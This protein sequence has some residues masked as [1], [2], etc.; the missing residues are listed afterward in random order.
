MGEF[1]V[2]LRKCSKTFGQGCTTSCKMAETLSLK[3]TLS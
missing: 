1:V 2:F 3:M